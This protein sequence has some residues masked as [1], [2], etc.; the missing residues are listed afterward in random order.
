L[1]PNSA[2]GGA[3]ITRLDQE[4]K[5]I[6]DEGACGGISE[7]YEDDDTFLDTEQSEQQTIRKTVGEALS[8]LLEQ[9]FEPSDILTNENNGEH[10]TCEHS[11]LTTCEHTSTKQS[12]SSDP[13]SGSDS[14]TDP[15]TYP[16]NI[17]EYKKALDHYRSITK[18]QGEEFQKY[19]D[20]I[21]DWKRGAVAAE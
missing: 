3:G 4:Q 10:T 18:Q 21:Q 5:G 2:E 11:D 13:T 15:D 16:S 1:V 6:T 17:D 19:E 20:C 9:S 14:S 7:Q 12:S 8:D